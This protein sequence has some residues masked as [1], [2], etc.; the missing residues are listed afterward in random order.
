MGP[1]VLEFR[2]ACQV[3]LP[4]SPHVFCSA[5]LITRVFVAVCCVV[6][7]GETDTAWSGMTRTTQPPPHLVHPA[8]PPWAAPPQLTLLSPPP[9]LPP[10]LHP[11]ES[12]WQWCCRLSAS[13]CTIFCILLLYSLCIV[14]YCTMTLNSSIFMFPDLC[15]FSLLWCFSLLY[16]FASLSLSCYVFLC[17]IFLLLYLLI[18]FLFPNGGKFREQ[19][20]RLMVSCSKGE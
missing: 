10:L 2:S 19:H 11:C 15:F 6:V 3:V 12:W 4:I 9:H 14:L 1:K 7:A 8:A 5:C 13:L 16:L 17:C 20:G 18:F